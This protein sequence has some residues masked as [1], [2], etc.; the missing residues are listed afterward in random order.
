MIKVLFGTINV[1]VYNKFTP[2][3][4]GYGKP[5]KLLNFNAKAGDYTWIDCNWYQ[6]HKLK[7]TSN[8]F[9]ATIQ[10]YKYPSTNNVHWPYFDYI[11]E[12]CK[13]EEFTPNSDFTFI[14][15]YEKVMKEMEMAEKDRC[16]SKLCVYRM[17]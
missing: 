5:K 9:C 1:D 6:T 13:I 15:I 17:I 4:D 11:S 7:N 16:Q 14:E 10:C 8:D 2:G 12:E 3:T